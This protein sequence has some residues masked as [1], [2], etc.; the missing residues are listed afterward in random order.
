MGFRTIIG[1][2]EPAMKK[3]YVVKHG[4]RELGRDLYDVVDTQN[5][6]TVLRS[7]MKTK[8][9]AEARRLNKMEAA[10]PGGFNGRRK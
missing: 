6:K 3:R 4:G 1:R 9:L 8:C 2:V 7:F 10:I 5:D